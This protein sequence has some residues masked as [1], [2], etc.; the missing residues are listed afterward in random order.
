[1]TGPALAVA[2]RVRDRI[3]TPAR[4]LAKSAP[5]GLLQRVPSG[6]RQPLH[7]LKDRCPWGEMTSQR[8]SPSGVNGRV[9]RFIGESN[10][11]GGRCPR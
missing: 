11:L 10:R 4:P 7:G 2:A 3:P 1:M 8:R 9:P 6:V 5:P